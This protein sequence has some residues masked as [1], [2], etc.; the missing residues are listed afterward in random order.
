MNKVSPLA[1]A[2]VL[3]LSGCQMATRAPTRP[4]F[5]QYGLTEVS[6]SVEVSAEMR[7]E[8][9]TTTKGSSSFSETRFRE[10]LN[11]LLAGFYYHP[12][13][14]EFNIDSM[15]GLE[16]R[17][18]ESTGDLQTSGLDGQ[19]LGYDAAIRIFKDMPYTA[20]IFTLRTESL[21]RQNFFTTNEAVVK[22]T[23]VRAGAKEWW[24]PS[25]LTASTYS[26]RGRGLN[27]F[28]EDRNSLRMEGHREEESAQ[29][30]YIAET[31]R[32]DLMTMDEPLDDYNLFASASNFFGLDNR[33][34]LHNNIFL[35]EQR[36]ANESSNLSTNSSYKHQWTD[37]LYSQHDM[38]FSSYG[39][40]GE[41]T[42]T[43]SATSMVNHQL[44]SSLNSAAGV[45]WSSARFG[46]G[47]LDTYGGN[48]NLAYIKETPIGRFGLSQGL[49]LQVRERGMLQGT[50][51]VN[52]EVLQYTSGVPMYLSNIAVDAASIVVKDQ[53]GLIVYTRNVDYYVVEIGSRIR[54]DIPVTSLIS[55]GD[56]LQVDYTFQP[57]PEQKINTVTSTTQVT[58][59]IENKANFSLGRTATQQSLASGYDDGTMED[60]TRTFASVHWFPWEVTT[61]SA[62][63]EDYESNISPFTRVSASV[64]QGIPFKQWLEWRAAGR[65]YHVTFGSDPRSEQGVAA[66]TNLYA[67]I[68]PTMSARLGAEF[69]KAQYRTDEGRGYSTELEVQKTLGLTQLT[70]SARFV[71]EEFEFADDQTL[72][73]V[74]FY[75]TREF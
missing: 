15:V 54:I 26:Y 38:L 17:D 61:V 49:D 37:N 1:A 13:L 19:N 56:T 72:L 20:E 55:D 67:Y 59:A 23:G 8:D 68:S 28:T 73:Y 35:R 64:D 33:H 66:S 34:R 22:E 14:L 65:T 30:D 21:T 71:E 50:A 70:L 47:S 42:E 74:Q 46:E 2:S 4:G 40:G 52:G 16:Q 39:R 3:I 5:D 60:S 53:S 62:D 9:R 29:Y 57:T 10:Q 32:V 43:I 7:E 69:H 6:G 45:R 58:L 36:G 75:V 18:F 41:D 51:A 48:G 24:I 12:K 44:F 25:T 27:D 63:F 11:L 31:S